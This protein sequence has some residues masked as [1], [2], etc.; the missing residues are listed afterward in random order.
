MKFFYYNLYLKNP[1][2]KA[3]MI[4][5]EVHFHDLVLLPEEVVELLK[6]ILSLHPIGHI[7]TFKEKDTND[8]LVGRKILDIKEALYCHVILNLKD[9]TMFHSSPISTFDLKTRA[10]VKLAFSVEPYLV[11]RFIFHR[12]GFDY[13]AVEIFVRNFISILK[14]LGLK[15]E[16][17]E[18]NCLHSRQ[19]FYDLDRYLTSNFAPLSEFWSKKLKKGITKASFADITIKPILKKSGELF[20]YSYLSFTKFTSGKIINMAAQK[21]ISL[22]GPI[23]SVYQL[24]LSFHSKSK[25]VT[26]LTETDLRKKITGADNLVESMTNLVPLT[27]KIPIKNDQTVERFLVENEVLIQECISMCISFYSHL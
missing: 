5:K 20:H 21:N 23:I 6:L 10:P 25:Y 11:V 15:K 18:F 19:P 13:K 2:S 3:L 24:M 12:I 9:T 16:V 27:A 22:I 14:R 8:T 26:I 7:E 4:S 1:D 17:P